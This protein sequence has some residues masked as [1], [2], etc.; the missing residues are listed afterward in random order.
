VAR[1]R[2]EAPHE[3]VVFFVKAVLH[4]LDGEYERALRSLDRLV[5]LDPAAHVVASYHRALIRIAQQRA[6]EAQREQERAHANT[7]DSPLMQTASALTLFY[8]G[9][10]GRADELMRALLVAHPNMHGVRPILAMC[11]SAQ[12]AH[13]Q[14]AQE[15][16]EQ[17]EKN[18]DADPDAAYWLASAHALADRRDQA[19]S[20]LARAIALGN[21]QRAW[22]AA[23]PTWSAFHDDARFKELLR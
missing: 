22:F 7:P 21:E 17:V 10:A 9:D 5:R 23:D 12:G 16:T 20:W 15:L 2:R 1:F 6:D 8:T 19:L 14:A 3:A 13:E 18:A 4:R 11:L